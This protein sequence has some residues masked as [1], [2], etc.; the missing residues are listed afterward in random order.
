MSPPSS[1]TA[2]TMTFSIAARCATTGMLG[3]AVSSS[4]P[5]VAARCA[6]ARARV[7]AVLSQNVT[8]PALGAKILDCLAGGQDAASA[9]ATVLDGNDTASYRQLLVVDD[10]GGSAIHTGANGLGV[11]GE[12]RG[13]DCVTGGNLLAHTAVPQHVA[14]AFTASQG[15][16]AERLLAAMDAGVAAGGEAGPVHSAGL[17]IV[18]RQPYPIVDLRSLGADDVV[19]D[20]R[21][22]DVENRA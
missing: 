10:R 22:I 8:D 5:A 21:G 2:K 16:L 19:V 12:A 3:V 7:G 17:L 15:H 6:H 9:L 20:L 13:V 4:S 14:D 11:V 18:D 1:R